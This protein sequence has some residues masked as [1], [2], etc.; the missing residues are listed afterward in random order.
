[1]AFKGGLS[2]PQNCYESS[3]GATPPEP[4]LGYSYDE[5]SIIK[6]TDL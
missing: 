5:K 1:L 2:F 4:S 3:R 6:Y